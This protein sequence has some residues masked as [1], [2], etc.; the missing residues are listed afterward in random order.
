MI[1][2]LALGE[3]GV[4]GANPFRGGG[5]QI[6]GQVSYRLRQLSPSAA[7]DVSVSHAATRNRPTSRRSVTSGTTKSRNSMDLP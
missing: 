2:F 7:R 6:K 5:Q 1:A 4:L 3:L